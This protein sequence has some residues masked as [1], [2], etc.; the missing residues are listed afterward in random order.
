MSD[1]LATMTVEELH[2]EMEAWSRVLNA[3]RGPGG[4]SNAERT[5]AQG[6]YAQAGVW[7]YRRKMEA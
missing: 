7:A 4:P 1:R 2:A 6:Y 3:P 5:M